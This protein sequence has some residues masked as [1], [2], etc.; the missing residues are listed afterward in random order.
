[1]NFLPITNYEGL[2]EV[3]DTGVVRSVS[4]IILGKDQVAYPFKGKVLAACPNSKL[5][6]Y[7]VQLWKDN[8]STTHYV[9]RL[10]AQTFIPNPEGKPE[11]NH[12]NGNRQDNSVL[13]LEWCT[14]TE[15]ADHAIK[16]GLKIY[17]NR[18]TEEEFLECL[19]AVLE[20]ESFL[21]LSKRVPYQVPFL[22]TKVRKIAK[23]HN[24]EHLL[25]QAL[26]EQKQR[27]ARV[28]GNPHSR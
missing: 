20:G 10:V 14:R 19:Q 27:R 4:R 17:T 28:N 24:L 15:N 7:Q 21:A 25:D 16:T 5:D 12:I 26:M 11:V 3:S 1:M 23:K 8:K 2:Y 13:N 18:L 6:Y 9:H 22:S